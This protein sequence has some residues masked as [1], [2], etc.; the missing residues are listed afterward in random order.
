LNYKLINGSLND[1]SKVKE[2]VLLNRGIENYKKYLNLTDDCLY[3]YSLLDNMDVAVE[4]LLKHI[5][6]KS[7][8]HIIPDVDVDGNTSA[9]I[10][11]MYLKQLDLNVN[12]TYSIH[13]GKQHGLSDDIQIPE[14]TNLVII[15]DAATNDIE[16]CKLL[17]EKG[18]DIIVLDHH[19]QEK[20]NP[21]TIVVNP[22]I[23]DYQNKSLAG[24]GVIYKFLQAIDNET[25]NNYADHYLDLVA[26]G[27]IG[28]LMDIRSFETKRLINKGLLKIRNKFLK[29]LINK[30]DYS[31][32]GVISIT[33]FQFY[34]V[35]LINGLIR[36]GDSNEKDMMFRA[37]IETDEMFKYKPRRKSKDDPEPEEINESIYDRTA[38]LCVNAKTRQ[39]KSKNSSFVEICDYVEKNKLENDKVLFVNCSEILDKNLT[40]VVAMKTASYYG[41]PCLMLR[42]T[43]DKN[44]NEEINKKDNIK[45]NIIFE[46]SARNINNSYIEDL[47]GFLEETGLFEYCT[48]HSNAL[49]IGIKKENI[50]PAIKLI[51][52]KLQNVDCEQYCLVDFIIDA[53]DLDIKFIKELD[54]L[55]DVYGQKVEES[56]IVIK[57]I[58]VCINHVQ[59]FEKTNTTMKFIYND[60]INFIKFK[61]DE[62]DE[63]LKIKKDE[64]R[65]GEVLT[66]NVIGKASI[67][68]FNGIL[69]PQI[70]I[71]KYEIVEEPCS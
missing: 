45:E 4:C 8:I 62:N 43:E 5:E 65:S 35:P 3:H 19:Q 50:K 32:H 57:N 2:T 46:G 52:E 63:I 38:R 29:A 36:S 20:E 16:Q 24:V 71:E 64:D 30:Q 15:P 33:N 39:D 18:I 66:L 58:E 56:K 69:S 14:G 67:N 68:N 61:I 28:D 59:L 55:K 11:Y 44:K 34:I 25:W 6:N 37:F 41:K 54:D 17:K 9:A 13:T 31:I 23:C 7:N 60:S 49:G 48:G 26:L 21:Y 1:I 12:L 27:L 47:K 42:K 51:N 53:E 40:G 10:L 22:Q 70:M